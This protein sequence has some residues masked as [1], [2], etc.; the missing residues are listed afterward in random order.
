M[1]VLKS[2]KSIDL[3]ARAYGV[4][5]NTIHKWKRSFMKKRLGWEA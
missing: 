4:H 3:K 5:P 2:Y 1:E